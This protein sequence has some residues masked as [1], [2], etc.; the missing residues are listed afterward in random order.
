MVFGVWITLL[1]P[2]SANAIMSG[3]V[4]KGYAIGPLANDDSL[5]EE[6]VASAILALRVVDGKE[7]EDDSFLDDYD[8]GDGGEAEED[9]DGED[10][11][12]VLDKL[13]EALK[14]VFL[15][16]STQYHSYVIVKEGP[17]SWSGSN[18]KFEPPKSIFTHLTE[19]DS[20][21]DP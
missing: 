3:L 7:D 15:K 17:S 1:T 2:L 4:R 19:E 18:I 6:G 8:A 10:V 14:E 5:Y 9:D 21:E 20:P 16:T 11:R 12:P 13:Q